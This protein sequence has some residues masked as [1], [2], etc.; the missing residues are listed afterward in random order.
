M[1]A[2][3]GILIVASVAGWAVGH[4]KSKPPIV[5]LSSMCVVGLT[6]ATGSAAVC[7]I[8]ILAAGVFVSVV[9]AYVEHAAP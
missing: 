7:L 1:T 2:V 3:V 9:E 5:I 8:S 6:W 4:L